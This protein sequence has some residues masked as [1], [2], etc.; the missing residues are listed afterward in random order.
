MTERQAFD[1]AWPAVVGLGM[2]MESYALL[3][4]RAGLTLSS[5]VWQVRDNSDKPLFRKAAIGVV[6]LYLGVHFLFGNGNR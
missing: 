5:H 4:D 1:V 3:R 2:G 6:C